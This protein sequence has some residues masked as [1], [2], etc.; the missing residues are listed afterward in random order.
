MRGCWGGE[1]IARVVWVP[2]GV[3]PVELPVVWLWGGAGPVSA[4]LVGTSA[5]AGIELPAVLG[6]VRRWGVA[7]APPAGFGGAAGGDA[8]MNSG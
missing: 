6:P 3:P 7:A 5:G 1:E 4:E 2:G 8:G